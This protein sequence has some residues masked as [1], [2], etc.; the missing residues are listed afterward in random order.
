MESSP[1]SSLPT[2]QKGLYTYNMFIQYSASVT[3]AEGALPPTVRPFKEAITL[4]CKR[5]QPSLPQEALFWFS[6]AASD[7]LEY[8]QEQLRILQHLD[9]RGVL[10]LYTDQI[11][12][13]LRMHDEDFVRHLTSLLVG[14]G[15][16]CNVSVVDTR[17][18]IG[19]TLP[20]N[21]RKKLGGCGDMKFDWVETFERPKDYGMTMFC[22][23]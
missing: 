23:F 11:P 15:A 5:F 3:Q 6:S 2:S 17:I 16:A 18:V 4:F 12:P 8:L 9:S 14:A 22:G 13:A 20:Q 19:M 10:Q 1:K 7:T 21:M